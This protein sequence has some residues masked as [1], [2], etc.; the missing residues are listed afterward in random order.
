MNKLDDDDNVGD[1]SMSAGVQTLRDENKQNPNE[2]PKVFDSSW[3]KLQLYHF[4][5]QQNGN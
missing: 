3:F 1:S 5:C 4:I 2:K